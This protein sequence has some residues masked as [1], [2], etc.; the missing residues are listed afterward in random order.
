[1]FGN[2]TC[3]VKS[4]ASLSDKQIECSHTKIKRGIFNKLEQ[5]N[6]LEQFNKL[7]HNC[8]LR[9]DGNRNIY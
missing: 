6:K 8:G 7:L 5:Y 1:M 4:I 2:A 9:T 3:S